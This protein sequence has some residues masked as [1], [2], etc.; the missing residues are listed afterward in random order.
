MDCLYNSLPSPRQLL[1]C[2]HDRCSSKRI[3]TSCWLIQKYQIWVSN[4]LHTNRASLPLTAGHTLD[5]G[6][7][8]LRV[9]TL[10][11]A[12]LWY[13]FINSVFFFLFSSF[14]FEFCGEFEAFAYGECL[15]KDVHL[16]DVGADG[17][18]AFDLVSVVAV[19]ENWSSLTQPLRYQT[20][21][22]IVE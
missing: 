6:T 18:E 3:K 14:E 5:Q 2:F 19:D 11:E 10:D 4:Q 12:E 20:T 9:L 15:K 13:N 16:L 21:T 22:Q 1:Q 17:W 7:A 8:D